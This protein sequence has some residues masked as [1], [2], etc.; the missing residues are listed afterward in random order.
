[1]SSG[2]TSVHVQPAQPSLPAHSGGRR[3]P[4]WSF[5]V[6]R[7][8]PHCG[9][10]R[11]LWKPPRHFPIVSASVF[12]QD[13]HS[14]PLWD[15]SLWPSEHTAVPTELVGVGQ[16]MTGQVIQLGGNFNLGGLLLTNRA[17]IVALRKPVSNLGDFPTLLTP[18]NCS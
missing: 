9:A 13:E 8:R 3:K 7:S 6:S 16:T 18:Q 11:H 2:S 10:C 4:A 5:A 14:Q 15:P 17:G 1:M 12:Q